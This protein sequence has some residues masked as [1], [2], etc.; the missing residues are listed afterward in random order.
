MVQLG[1]GFGL[2]G[3]PK[4]AVRTLFRFLLESAAIETV[5]SRGNWQML[6]KTQRVAF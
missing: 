2:S 6:L 5:L 3:Q 4:A 1:Y